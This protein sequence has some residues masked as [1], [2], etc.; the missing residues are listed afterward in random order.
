M[1]LFEQLS[2]NLELA[3]LGLQLSQNR[4]ESELPEHV[5]DAMASLK[6]LPQKF[7]Q[8]L[9]IKGMNSDSNPY[10]E[11]TESRRIAPFEQYLEWLHSALGEEAMAKFESLSPEGSAASIGQV[12]SAILKSGEK[13]AVKVQ[14]PKVKSAIE[15]DLNAIGWL[16]A[17][18]AGRA[19]KFS[20]EAYKSE[21]RRSLLLETDYRN[22]LKTLLRFSR[23]LKNMDSVVVPKPIE[24]LSSDR[25][26][27]MSWIQGAHINEVR[28][29]SEEA[30]TQVAKTL[31]SLYLHSWL[32]WG[33]G[34]A[35]PHPGNYR[36]RKLP[37]GIQ[38]GVLDFGCTL[39]L[40]DSARSALYRLIEPDITLNEVDAVETFKA[41]GFNAEILNPLSKK[42][43]GVAKILRMPFAASGSFDISTWRLS[44]RISEH[45]GEEKWNF[46]YAGPAQL[47]GF[48]RATVGLIQYLKGL[49]MN[50]SWADILKQ[51]SDNASNYES[52]KHHGEQQ[53]QILETNHNFS[54]DASH[55]KIQVTQDNK[56]KV[57]ITLPASAAYELYEII[58]EEVAASILKQGNNLDEIILGI[59]KEGLRKRLLFQSEYTDKRVSIE[60]I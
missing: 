41:L 18:I 37:S 23:Y 22:E 56:T 2:R 4:A 33:E 35:D 59:K 40:A 15:S 7:A 51:V 36:F 44:E 14:Y 60:L 26:L 6:G 47:I 53:T 27:T 3:K 10:L 57:Q 54:R 8:V 49:E 13:V 1:S 45:L 32:V 46:R 12:H 20:L 16:S 55:L 19:H 30:R 58:P 28:N 38:I 43:L 11:L 34:H 42:L 24:E 5:L 31:L 50:I 25:V 29:W 17:P 52:I 39:T 9:S 21:L 48:I